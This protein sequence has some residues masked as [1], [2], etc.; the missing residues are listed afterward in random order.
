MYLN[1]PGNKPQA[2][3]V[4]NPLTVRPRVFSAINGVIEVTK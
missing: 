1:I 2:T 4:N 3:V